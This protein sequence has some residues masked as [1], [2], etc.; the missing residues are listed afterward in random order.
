MWVYSA[1]MLAAAALLA[2]S[3]VLIYRG[4]TGLIH[5]YHQTRVKDRAAYGRAFGKALMVLAAVP[6][7]SGVIALAGMSEKAL[8]AASLVLVLGFIP[9]MIPILMVQKK[10]NNGL[11]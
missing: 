1:I 10:Y 5:S 8:A 4:N 11:F 7:L 9:G 2:V 6:L 3:A